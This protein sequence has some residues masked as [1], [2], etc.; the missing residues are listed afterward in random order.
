MRA[1]S[2]RIGL[3]MAGKSPWGGRKNGNGSGD[4]GASD[5]GPDGSSS[6][7]GGPRGPKNPWLPGGGG[8]DDDDGKRRSANIEDIFRNRGPEGPRRSGG[9]PGGPNFRMPTGPGGRSWIPLVAVLVV[10]IALLSTMIHIVQPEERAV[11]KTL[12]NYTRTYEPGFNV[13]LPW[14]IETVEVENV[15]GVRSFEIPGESAQQKLILTGDQNLVDVSYLVRWNIKDLANYKFELAEPEVTIQEVAEAAMRASVAEKTLND[16]FSGQGRSEIETAVRERMQRVLDGYRSGIQ[17]RGVEIDKADPPSEVNDA[18]RDVLVAQQNADAARNQARG[19]AQ[20]VLQN[21]QGET[22]AF[23]R[24]YEEY[25]QAPEVTRRRL[26]YETMERVLRQNDKVVIE[27]DGV[28]PYL[29]LPELRRRQSAG[30]PAPTATATA[31]RPAASPSPSA[32]GQE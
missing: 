13:S 20:Q 11:V 10:S 8:S 6:G 19:V 5:G 23:D 16:T 15:Q 12:G 1:L 18:F 2:A 7:P 17:V 26:Y 14:P 22:A 4:D 25:R 24:V 21:A 30:T 27:A 9:G 32:T 29:P 3:A 31:P 28:T